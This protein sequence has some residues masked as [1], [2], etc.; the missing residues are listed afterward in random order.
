M[1]AVDCVDRHTVALGHHLSD[2]LFRV[3]HRGQALMELLLELVEGAEVAGVDGL[4]HRPDDRLDSLGL[5]GPADRTI[6]RLA[7]TSSLK[8]APR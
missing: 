7:A 3:G 2:S 8:V 6:T 4:D 1:A 5:A